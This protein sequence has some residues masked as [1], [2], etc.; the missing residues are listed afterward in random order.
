MPRST[1]DQGEYKVG[2]Q[3]QAEQRYRHRQGQRPARRRRHVDALVFGVLDREEGLA[4]AATDD[5]AN[6]GPIEDTR[7][8]A[9]GA[10]DLQPILRWRRLVLL[11]GGHGA[12]AGETV[13]ADEEMS[14]L[15][16]P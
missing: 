8:A 11:T 2:R 13:L 1:P 14:D 10:V 5:P 12:E 6:E 16:I 4:V 7:L 15:G 9:G 3:T